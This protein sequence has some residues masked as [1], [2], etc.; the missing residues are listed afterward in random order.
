MECSCNRQKLIQIDGLLVVAFAV[1]AHAGT[2]R[3]ELT[4]NNVLLEAKQRVDLALDGSFG[5]DAR[6][7][8]ERCSGP[9]SMRACTSLL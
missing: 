8:L 4:D 1:L 5:Q 6:G 7:L 3:D 9:A 2:R